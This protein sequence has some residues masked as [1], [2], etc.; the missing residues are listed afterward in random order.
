MQAIQVKY[1]GPTNTKPSRLKAIAYG[2][3]VIVSYDY[4]QDD[5]EYAA[6]ALMKK[7]EWGN[8][9]LYRGSLPNGDDVYV[10]GSRVGD[11]I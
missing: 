8:R 5:W 9:E 6:R 1:L 2:G 3:S 10:L 4:G 7:L 11:E